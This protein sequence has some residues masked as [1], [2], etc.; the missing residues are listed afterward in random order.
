[1]EKIQEGYTRVS[2]ILAQWNH[3]AHINPKVLENKCRIGTNVH[4]KISSS[5]EGIYIELQ[6]DEEGYFE[7]WEK[8]EEELQIVFVET[9]KRFYC[10]LLK[11]TGCVD[12]IIHPSS[13]ESTLHI[14]DY[15]T[16]YSVNEKMWALQASFYHYLANKCLGEISTE[17][18]FVHLQR[19][20]KKAK[21][22]VFHC[23]NKLF[24]VCLSALM[25]YRYLND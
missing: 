20:G 14:V 4:E 19:D 8:W 12:A 23:E 25:T 15:K 10:D 11:I 18:W 13:D 16:S 3:L 6:S 22:H 5:I 21:S 17:V 24:E 1:M 9:E 2:S 7:S